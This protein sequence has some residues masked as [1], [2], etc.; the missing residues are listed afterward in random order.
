MATDHDH[1][2]DDSNAIQEIARLLIEQ[3]ET[4]LTSPDLDR[5]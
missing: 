1:Q 3:A 2:H 5:S 4:N